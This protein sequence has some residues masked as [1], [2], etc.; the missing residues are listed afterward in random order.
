MGPQGDGAAVLTPSLGAVRYFVQMRLGLYPC[1]TSRWLAP[2]I[3]F[4]F[5]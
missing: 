2:R 3:P 1:S 4:I 5:H